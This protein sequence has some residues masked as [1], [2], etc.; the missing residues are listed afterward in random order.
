MPVDPPRTA[1]VSF[2]PAPSRS[3]F[4]AV[5]LISFGGPTGRDEIRPFLRNVLRGRRVPPSRIEAVARH[6]ERFDGVSPLTSITRRQAAGLRDRLAVHGPDLPV[7]VGMRN[8][9]P[10]L[11]D[12]L[13]EMAA[14]GVDR[15]L[16]VILAAHH[17][18]SSCG[19]YRQNVADARRALRARGI[20]DVEVLFA[21]GWHTHAGFVAAN[22][23]RIDR[24]RRRLPDTVRR[25]ARVVFTAHSI[26]CS[27]AAGPGTR[28]SSGKRPAWC[29]RGSRPTTGRSSTRAGA[30]DPRIRGSS[31][32]SATTCAPS[33][34]AGWRRRSSR[35]SGFVADHIEVLYDLDTEAAAVCRTLGLPM[36]RAA[37]V[38]DHPAFL[39]ALADVTRA[40]CARAQGGRPLPIAPAVPPDASRV[41]RWRADRPGRHRRDEAVPTM[42]SAA[43]PDRLQSRIGAASG[44]RQCASSRNRSRRP[45][46]RSS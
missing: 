13:A 29:A 38:N 14:A 19:Q 4:G 6:Y 27:M 45:R 20:A 42:R 17:S 7:F 15:A 10:F 46:H 34:P 18:Y 44:R 37:A 30:A 26:P 33:T 3:P 31:R 41:R 5:L 1:A 40:A 22:A 23:D 21:P 28:R 35:R 8:W 36:R 32:T 43:W 2:P 9:R 25:A 11:D 39:D 24:A 16:G 12:T